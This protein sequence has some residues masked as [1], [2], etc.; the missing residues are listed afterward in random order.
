MPLSEGGLCPSR[1]QTQRGVSGPQVPVHP[2]TE[3]GG[4]RRV[5]GS[6]METPITS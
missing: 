3:G 4:A 5:G 6:L 2:G 1:T